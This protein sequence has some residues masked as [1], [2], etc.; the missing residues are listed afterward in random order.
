MLHFIRE[1][2]QGWLAWLIVGLL[3]IPFALWGINSYFDVGQ[4]MPLA[5]V[6]DVEISQQ[7]F[8]RS[9]QQQRARIQEMFKDS[10]IPE[11]FDKQIQQNT[12]ERLVENKLVLQEA[13]ENNYRIPNEF[14]AS[15]IS[16]FPNFQE[17]GKFS[18]ELYESAMSGRG[19]S[20]GMFEWQMRQALLHDQVFNGIERTAFVTNKAISDVARLQFQERDITYFKVPVERY[21][22]DIKISQEEIEKYYAENSAGYMTPERVSLEYIEL[23][24]EA[25][26]KDINVSEEKLQSLYE[27]QKGMFGIPE[28]RRASHILFEVA[29]DAAGDVVAQAKQQAGSVIEKLKAGGDFSELA[30]EF[31]QDPGS[32]DQ[33]GDLGFFAKGIMDP[34]FEEAAFELKQGQTSSLVRSDFGFHIIKLEEIRPGKTKP[35]AEVRATLLD[36][37]RQSEAEKIYYENAEI[38]A[39]QSYEQPDSLQPAADAVDAKIQFTSLFPRSG[40][41]GLAADPQ[42][43]KA[44]YSD[45]VLNQGLNS[46]LIEINNNR[47]VVIRIKE[48]KAASQK[49]LAVVKESIRQQLVMIKAK[50]KVANVGKLIVQKLNDKVS[51]KKIAKQLSI[52]LK[53]EGFVK[54][55][56]SSVD[57][58]VVREA[59]QLQAPTTG[60]P[61]MKEFSLSNGDFVVLRVKAVRDGDLS[62]VSQEEQKSLKDQL[63]SQAGNMDYAAMLDLIK[64][65]A[66]IK[67]NLDRL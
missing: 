11:E 56:G 54:R 7:E 40:G 41:A 35:F 66:N 49:P 4:E 20:T 31:S 1:K 17:D 3:I 46:E 48:H 28:E 29:M 26:K 50:E 6:N 21:K 23:S 60:E 47:S 27:E 16:K 36:N 44:A 37:Y 64:E 58:N 10:P 8:Q 53:Q 15:E 65:G 52:E 51:E 30:K 39:N 61:A 63:L 43:L 2:A 62:K 55:T 32:A 9:Y 13:A 42:V 45:E 67:M 38:L 14:L 12:L 25:L 24:S 57:G 18:K 22:K 59:F 34:A 33:G 19:M 5:T